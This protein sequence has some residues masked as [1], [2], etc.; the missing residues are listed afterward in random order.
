MR[1]LWNW[2]NRKSKRTMPDQDPVRKDSSCCGVI[3]HTKRPGNSGSFRKNVIPIPEF[4]RKDSSHCGVICHTKRPGN[5]GSFRKNVIQRLC[6]CFLCAVLVFTS[7]PVR[8]N[9]SAA[10]MSAEMTAELTDL[11]FS[12]L[13]NAMLAAGA[14]N[15]EDISSESAS[16]LFNTFMASL[17]ESIGMGAPAGFE[18]VSGVGYVMDA[19][20]FTVTMSDGSVVTAEDIVAAWNNT[21]GT[22]AKKLA[23]NAWKNFKVISGGSG[24]TGGN[25]NGNKFESVGWVE[26]TKNMFQFLG[27]WAAGVFAG[28]IS[29]LDRDDYFFNSKDAVVGTVTQY[30]YG[31]AYEMDGNGNYIVRGS[32][33]H[34]YPDN[35]S[36]DGEYFLV[37]FADAVPYKVVFVK[38]NGGYT[39]YELRNGSISSGMTSINLTET[40]FNSDGSVKVDPY[41]VNKSL[42]GLCSD[43]LYANIPI[44]STAEEAI[45]FL[46]EGTDTG[47]QNGMRY[48]YA[49]LA[50]AVADSFSPFAGVKVDANAIPEL[51]PAISAAVD[52][53]PDPAPASDPSINTDTYIAAVADAVASNAPD[54]DPDP[55][56]DPVPELDPAVAI[57]VEK[58]KFDLTEIFPFCIPFDLVKLLDALCAD[59]V[60]PRFEIPF[61]VPVLGIDMVWVIDMAIFDT[62]AEVF[63]VGIVVGYVIFLL[64]NTFKLIKW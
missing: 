22:S 58:S 32:S 57:E 61:V 19:S 55:D 4:V 17:A 18:Y 8:V 63:R 7:C 62:A 20:D 16:D 53:L 42:T 50:D 49:A 3:C 56:P 51:Y 24:G 39:S 47:L 13:A 59:P 14:E 29:G 43:F 21:D 5:S 31:G 6:V 23:E 44:F 64:M 40:L 26:A 11:L 1:I 10:A 52:A 34:H 2:Q 36:F 38:N 9:A 35:A 46:K 54:T 25:N 28:A 48:D 15:F 30:C 37:Q 45:D 27:A 12:L 33:L 41:S 60:A